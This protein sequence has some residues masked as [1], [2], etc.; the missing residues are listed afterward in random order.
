[1][2]RGH[3]PRP[4]Q[5]GAAQPERGFVD[6]GHPKDAFLHYLD[7]GPQYRS[8]KVHPAVRQPIAGHVLGNF[9]LESDID[10][11]GET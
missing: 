4:G 7:L 11:K 9:K 2:R 5:E 1:M 6:I 10:K 8:F 3:L